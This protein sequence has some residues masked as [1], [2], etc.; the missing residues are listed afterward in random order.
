MSHSLIVNSESFNSSISKFKDTTLKV[1]EI[2]ESITQL[3]KEIDGENETWKSKTA[4]SV[5]EKYSET[6]SR[7][8][9]INETF[10]RYNKFLTTTLEDYQK[11]EKKQVVSIESQSDNL[12]VNE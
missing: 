7:F 10:E 8:K 12:D 6:E 9:D 5:H 4:V 11:E 2:L 1:K 3:M